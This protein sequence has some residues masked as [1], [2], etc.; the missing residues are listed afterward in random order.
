MV[1][2]RATQFVRPEHRAIIGAL[3]AA[4][5]ALLAQCRCWFGGGT[6]IVLDIGEYRLSKDLDFLCADQDG[7]RVLRSGIAKQGASFLFGPAVT[8]E[9][10]FR[11]DQYGIRGI[12]AHDR[13]PIRFEIIREARISLEGAPH[14]LVPL[15]ALSDTDRVAEKLLAN[16]DR[17]RDAAFALRDAIDLG[18]IAR[19]QGDFPE[20]AATKAASA[21]GTL[22]QREAAWAADSL[23]DMA[24]RHRVGAALGMEAALV[25]A[26]G[27]AFRRACKRLWS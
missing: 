2:E 27:R 17:G 21:Y 4:D 7:Y 26:A 6:A 25:D 15:M 14:S 12:I 24:A 23:R 10:A 8:Q 18:M 16:A 9:R 20:D 3:H 5:A 1:D 11:A 19:A 13:L 22:V